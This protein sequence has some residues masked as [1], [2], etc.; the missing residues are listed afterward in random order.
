LR[1]ILH[2][3]MDAFF[4]AVEQR[5]DPN[6]RGRPVAVGGGGARGV[7]MAA[8]YEARA[9][10]VRSAMP[11]G[12]AARACPELIFVRPRMDVYRETGMAVRAIFG[13]FTHLV[14]PLALDEAYLDVTEHTLQHGTTATAVARAI[15]VSV[16]EE[17]GLTVSAGVSNCK[18]VAKVASGWQK[19]DGLTVIAPERVESFLH[20]L[21]VDALWGVGPVTA[22][23]LRERGI[24]KLVDVRTADLQLLRDA[25]GS[26]AEWLEQLSRGVDD[27]PVVAEHDPKSSGSESTYAHDLTDIADIRAEI[28]GMGRSAAAWLE[29]KGL[30]ARTVTIK[31]RYSDF[32]TITRSHT[33]PPTCDAENIARRAVALLDKT[34]AGRTPVRLLGVSVHNLCESVAAA[35]HSKARLPFDV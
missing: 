21:S 27:R 3:D 7:V 25:V 30:Y 16:R 15:K 35:K 29:R 24:E 32:T 33:E 1:K 8:S 26:L 22:K 17:L 28:D 6:L 14:E 11:G 23:K 20:G 34:E 12:A 19:P 13:R 31:V 4:A 9:F 18:F 10:G 2:C 5:D